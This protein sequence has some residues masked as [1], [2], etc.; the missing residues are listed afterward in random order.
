MSMLVDL[1]G[2]T[3]INSPSSH[4]INHNDPHCMLLFFLAELTLLEEAFL[5]QACIVHVDRRDCPTVQTHSEKVRPLSG[6]CLDAFV[7]PTPIR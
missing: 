7:E 5:G 3:C 4:H 1:L 2:T 6:K